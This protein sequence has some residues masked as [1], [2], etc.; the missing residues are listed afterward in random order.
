MVRKLGSR[1]SRPVSEIR[2]CSVFAVAGCWLA[3]RSG[4]GGAEAGSGAAEGVCDA[5]AVGGGA[6]GAVGPRSE[7]LGR[8]RGASRWRRR[9]SERSE[10]VWRFGC[11]LRRAFTAGDQGEHDSAARYHGE[12]GVLIGPSAGELHAA[13]GHVRDRSAEELDARVRSGEPGHPGAGKELEPGI[14]PAEGV[15]APRAVGDVVYRG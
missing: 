8:L 12:A 6:R 1:P 2:S 7:L 3:A 5:R 11:E 15:L 4:A 13:P 14:A 9:W 10:R